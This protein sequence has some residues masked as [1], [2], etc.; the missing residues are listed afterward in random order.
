MAQS[1]TAP[2][3]DPPARRL[4]IDQRYYAPILVS[5]ILL[6]GQI[7]FRFLTSPMGTVLGI[8]A[9]IGMEILLS[10]L[11]TRKMPNVASAYVSGISVGI[12]VQSTAVW[13]YMLCSAIAILSKYLIRVENRHIWNPSNL[14]IVTLLLLAPRYV[15]T[16]GAQAGN[17]FFAMIVIWTVGSIIIYR[18]KRFHICFTYVIFF[19]MYAAMRAAILGHYVSHESFAQEAAPLSGPMYQLFVFFMITDPKTTV[20]SWRGQVLVAFLVATAENL[21]R[22]YGT[23]ASPPDGTLGNIVATHAPYFALTLM[24]PA[25]NLIEIAQKRKA[26]KTQ[27]AAAA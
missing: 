21:M 11:F 27:A 26:R 17:S 23:L 6:V 10:L 12:L 1:L 15:S 5:L 18:L 22:I 9:S 14:G 8:L 2:A 20:N 7:S 19:L 16:L 4:H 3:G 13:P 24:G 25:A